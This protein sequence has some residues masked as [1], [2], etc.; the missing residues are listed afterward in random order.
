MVITHIH[1][2]PRQYDCKHIYWVIC[3]LLRLNIYKGKVWFHYIL[4]ISMVSWSEYWSWIDIQIP[5]TGTIA[6]ILPLYSCWSQAVSCY[7]TTVIRSPDV[8]YILPI[9]TLDLIVSIYIS[10]D[11]IWLDWKL[12][13]CNAYSDL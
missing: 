3:I 7:P 2:T 13:L 1:I 11:S 8:W 6:W 12:M 4:F 9:S 5:I 10:T